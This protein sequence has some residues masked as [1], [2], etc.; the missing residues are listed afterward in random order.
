VLCK[1]Q[2]EVAAGEESDGGGGAG[3]NPPG[4]ATA[5]TAELLKRMDAVVAETGGTSVD[6]QPCEHFSIR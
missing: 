1:L 6:E 2:M 5:P 3:S 4:G